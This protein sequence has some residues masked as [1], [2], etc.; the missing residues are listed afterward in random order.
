[1][2]RYVGKER[3]NAQEVREGPAGKGGNKTQMTFVRK[4][5]FENEHLKIDPGNNCNYS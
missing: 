5:N 3:V 1:M 4:F 2:L